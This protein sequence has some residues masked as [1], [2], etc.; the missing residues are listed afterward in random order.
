MIELDGRLRAVRDRA[1]EASADLRARA[2]AIDAD[3]D[4]MEAH[5]DSPVFA[6]MREG[7]TPVELRESASGGAPPSGAGGCLE[8]VVAFT[9]TA[10]GDAATALACPGPGLAG[11]MVCLLGDQAQR[12]LFFRRLRGGRT[13]SFFAMTEAA[14]GSDAGAMDTRFEPDGA[15]GWLLF[16]SKRRGSPCSVMRSARS[17]LA[18]DYPA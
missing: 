6:A 10:C 8:T 3:P 1:R 13:W 18:T 2:L 9:E 12:E 15:G 5:F 16:G 4:A 11:V 7:Q 17:A 14:H